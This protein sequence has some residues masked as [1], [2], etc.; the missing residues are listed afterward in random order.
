MKRDLGEPV[1]TLRVHVYRLQL[2]LQ[3]RAGH[4]TK[5]QY[6]GFGL[7]GSLITSFYLTLKINLTTRNNLKDQP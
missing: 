6:D 5:A 2:L 3:N 7:S 4:H 1:D